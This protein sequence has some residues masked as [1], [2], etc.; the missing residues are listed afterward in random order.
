MLK[1]NQ[2][3]INLKKIMGFLINSIYLII[4]YKSFY[5]VPKKMF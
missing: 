4:I 3:R 1:S 5:N 2:Y